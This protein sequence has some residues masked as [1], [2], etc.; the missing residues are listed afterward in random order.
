ML[1]TM[2]RASRVQAAIQV[3]KLVEDIEF[4]QKQ[5]ERNGIRHQI[6]GFKRFEQAALWMI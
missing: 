3:Q 4:S 2:L 5:Q 6:D 1:T